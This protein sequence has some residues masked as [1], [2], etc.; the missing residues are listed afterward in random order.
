MPVGEPSRG[1]AKGTD[2]G[3]QPLAEWFLAVANH[4]RELGQL[5]QIEGRE[6]GVEVALV[7]V[8]L[9]SRGPTPEFVDHLAFADVLRSNDR[10]I[11]IGA[12]KDQFVAQIEHE[13]VCVTLIEGTKDG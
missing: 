8:G 10:T 2:R 7:T 12:G 3:N 9:F 6:M 11:V 4:S 13:Y 1:G 5:P